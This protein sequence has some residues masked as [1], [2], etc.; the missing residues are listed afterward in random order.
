M[1]LEEEILENFSMWVCEIE[2]VL[3]PSAQD[4]RI[5]LFLDI[6]TD[7]NMTFGRTSE[8][9]SAMVHHHSVRHNKAI[10][11]T[12]PFKMVRELEIND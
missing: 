2:Q 8:L 6:A 3:P 1:T 9:V 7:N 11:L 4:H 12:S 5:K 10:R